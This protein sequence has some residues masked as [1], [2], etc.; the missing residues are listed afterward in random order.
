[1]FWAGNPFSFYSDSLN[2]KNIVVNFSVS[3]SSFNP[4]DIIKVFIWNKN[5]QE[6]IIKENII[7][8]WGKP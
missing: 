2:T 5:K 7:V 3:I 8:C 1:M 6:Y 4:T